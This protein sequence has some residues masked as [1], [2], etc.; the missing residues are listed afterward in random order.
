MVQDKNKIE[1]VVTLSDESVK[2][3]ASAIGCEILDVM[4][5]LLEPIIKD[6][7]TI[8]SSI[9]DV[10]SNTR[11]CGFDNGSEEDEMKI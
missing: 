9:D 10:E 11:W 4:E 6:I 1:I 2:E 5:A 3:I 7:S 8:K